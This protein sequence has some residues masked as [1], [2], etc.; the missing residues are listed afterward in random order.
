MLAQLT[1]GWHAIVVMLAVA[2]LA[3]GPALVAQA[4]RHTWDATA[5][6]LDALVARLQ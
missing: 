2:S 3:A 4:A 5:A 6:A 1:A